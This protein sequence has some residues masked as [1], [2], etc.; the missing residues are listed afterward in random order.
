MFSTVLAACSL[1]CCFM[2]RIG[3]NKYHDPIIIEFYYC[4]S[5]AYYIM[6]LPLPNSCS[7]LSGDSPWFGQ[8]MNMPR[9]VGKSNGMETVFK[10][11]IGALDLFK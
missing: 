11:R 5:L 4:T 10:S 8:L 7:K 1:L 2:E 9:K 6:D 3:N